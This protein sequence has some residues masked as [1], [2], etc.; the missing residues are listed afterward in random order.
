MSLHTPL[1]PLGDVEWLIPPAGDAAAFIEGAPALLIHFWSTGCPLCEEGAHSITRWRT[2]FE[3]LGLR[4]I[5]IFQPR[6]EA[7]VLSSHELLRH[8]R[9]RM[10]ISH[11]CILDRH[12]ALAER[13]GNP[14][15]PGYYVYDGAR[16]L[17]HRQMGSERLDVI[18]ALLAR[19][20]QASVSSGANLEV[21]DASTT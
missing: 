7:P 14:Y 13:F 12:A 1:P 3:P 5:G 11:P 21:D 8:A 18:E 20:V 2:R 4:T 17:R 10:H 9:E 19:L 15:A 6:A 16:Q